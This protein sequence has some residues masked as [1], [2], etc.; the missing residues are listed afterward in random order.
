MTALPPLANT[1]LDAMMANVVSAYNADARDDPSA[2]LHARVLGYLILHTTARPR[3]PQTLRA[4]P[5]PILLF[6]VIKKFKGGF[7]RGWG[8]SY[9]FFRSVHVG[10]PAP[11]IGFKTEWAR[12]RSGDGYWEFEHGFNQGVTAA[13]EDYAQHY[14]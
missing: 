13:R 2:Q 6:P 8:D 10:A 5:S 12:R 14:C 7:A 9:A 11:E 3:L 1:R 4:W